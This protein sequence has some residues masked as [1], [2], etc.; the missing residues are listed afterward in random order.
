MERELEAPRVPEPPERED[1]AP[2][3][4][5]P[6]SPLVEPRDDEPVREDP[7]PPRDPEL[8]APELLEPAR[9][10]CERADLP[11]GVPEARRGEEL[12]LSGKRLLLK[13]ER[14]S[15]RRR[16]ASLTWTIKA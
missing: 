13:G 14:A 4:E 7:A 8:L 10:D 1:G 15:Y 11:L 5:E 12:D 9:G 3:S 2:R 6:R 16:Q